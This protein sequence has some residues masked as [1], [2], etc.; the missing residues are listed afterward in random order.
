M[1]KTLRLKYG[2]DSSLSIAAP[3][4][5]ANTI[6]K[7]T[8]DAN[9]SRDFNGSANAKQGNS[10][11]GLITVTVYDVL[12]NGVLRVRGE[13]WLKLNNGDEFIRLTGNVRVEDIDSNKCSVANVLLMPALNYAGRGAFADSNKSGLSLTE[14][15]TAHGSRSDY[16]I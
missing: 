2:K 15:S 3:T 8:A 6:D 5:G 7:F 10:L 14:C 12:P 4:F 16:L 13:K 1:I 9:A 11:S